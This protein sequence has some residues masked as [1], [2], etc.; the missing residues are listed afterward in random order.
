MFFSVILSVSD[1]IDYWK[2]VAQKKN[3]TKK[4]REAASTFSELLE[5][6]NEE[7]RLDSP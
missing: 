1:E 7:I 3:A 6:I 2:N 4:E 5:D